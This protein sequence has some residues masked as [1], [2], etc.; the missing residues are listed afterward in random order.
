MCIGVFMRQGYLY[1]VV[2]FTIA[3][4]AKHFVVHGFVFAQ[5]SDC[6]IVQCD[7]VG[8]VWLDICI[9]FFDVIQG[10]A[11]VAWNVKTRGFC[12]FAFAGFGHGFHSLNGGVARYGCTVCRV[13]G[14][15]LRQCVLCEDNTADANA[16]DCFASG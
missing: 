6:A 4:R 10:C 1:A 9:C 5:D 7:D 11:T 14:D 13:H 8:I 16:S 12:P 15:L 3:N 2:V